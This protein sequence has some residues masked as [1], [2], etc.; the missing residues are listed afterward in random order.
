MAKKKTY[1][2]NPLVA[3]AKKEV[4][5]T[6]DES[7]ASDF[8]KSMDTEESFPEELKGKLKIGN[9][10]QTYLGRKKDAFKQT[11]YRRKY[12]SILEYIGNNLINTE[13]YQT[14]LKSQSTNV[15]YS[16]VYE[17]GSYTQ[18]PVLARNNANDDVLRIPLAKEP[19]A[20][21]KIMTAV[22]VLGGNVPDGRFISS[23]KI[24]SRVNYELWKRTWTNPLAN[25]LNT[26][27]YLY[28]NLFLTGFGAYRIFP[29]KVQH[30][31]NGVP[32]ILFDDIYRQALDPR[33]TWLG[34]SV[35]IYDRWSHGEVL[36]EIDQEY[37]KFCEKYPEA[38]HFDL[39]FTSSVQESQVD[40]AQ[41]QN[42]V[43]IRYYEDPIANKYCVACGN[44][45]VYE[46][47][48]PNEEGWGH[49]I[50]ANCFIKDPNDPYGVGLVE[51]M[52]GNIELYD[53]INRLNAEQVEAEISPLI[54]GINTGVGEMTYRRGPNVI[55]A[56]NQGT[57]LD[58]I[59]TN[60]NVQQ[61]IMFADKQKQI[62][63]ENTGINDILAGQA[64]EGTLGTT[65]IMKE[66]AL[67]RLIIPRNSVISGLEQDAY[68]TVS[69][70]QQTYTVDKVLEFDT[71]EDIKQFTKNN[72][73]YFIEDLVPKKEDEDE[74]GDD[75]PNFGEDY[76]VEPH[77]GGEL[78]E[79]TG[80]ERDY[81]DEKKGKKKKVSY[82]KKVRL[83][84]EIKFNDQ[85]QHEDQIEELTNEYNIPISKL[86]DILNERG[87]MSDR[88]QIV[89][90]GTS[91]LLPS[92]EIEKQRV[93]QIYSMV[94]PASSQIIQGAAQ[95]PDL[96]RV[97]LTQMEHVLDENKQSIYDWFPKDIYDRIMAPNPAANAGPAQIAAAQQG[98]GGPNGGSMGLTGAS[99]Q[100]MMNQPQP[101]SPIGQELG[102]MFGGQNQNQSPLNSAMS[103]SVG[104]AAVGNVKG[105]KITGG[106][107]K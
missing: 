62:I 61:S 29:K 56:K 1:K 74:S 78:D 77:N 36:Y 93:N 99:G 102:G 3:K 26:L 15:A 95:L 16:F 54:F 24:Y 86:F 63:S 68:M 101:P 90:D 5:N 53:Y 42:F 8:L 69:W 48:M 32:R 23:D 17:N 65:V 13:T 7:Y 25:G 57:D 50:W 81:G 10:I 30:M 100:P 72:P 98:Q 96:S 49:V 75:E 45:P 9:K 59:K 71:D 106:K 67:N 14:A 22:S 20:F 84:F 52:R 55:N 4:A 87:H 35:N 37:S 12:D 105:G 19:V 82:S 47:E 21:S 88:I 80:E 83:N 31:S 79:S 58:I 103:A 27:Q 40:E 33:R 18:I 85:D 28:Q 92:D 76:E 70:I 2:S 41:K 97:L 34:N 94:G 64:G 43:T 6:D 46:G 38:V 104:R 51:L 66:A 73:D 107:A 44:F 60:G 89:I 91:T 11:R 39:E